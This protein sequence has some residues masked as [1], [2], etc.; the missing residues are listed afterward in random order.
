MSQQRPDEVPDRRV[1]VVRT[2][3]DPP[4]QRPEK[5]GTNFVPYII[6]GLTSA[7]AMLLII[8]IWML[9]SPNNPLTGA[10]APTARSAGTGSNAIINPLDV[11]TQL[12]AVRVGT[13]VPGDYPTVDPALVP[14][15]PT[16]S[17]APVGSHP[18]TTSAN[19]KPN[20][21]LAKNPDAAQSTLTG[22][23]V[24]STQ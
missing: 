10:S 9:M 14:A 13:D 7:L 17:P 22:Y 3:G 21:K 19:Y 4:S 16:G 2:G 1:R 20:L 15:V 8:A 18:L 24:R 11:P 6:G 12:P 5:R 23:A